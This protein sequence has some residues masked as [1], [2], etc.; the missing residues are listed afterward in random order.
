VGCPEE[1][2]SST[3]GEGPRGGKEGGF[4]KGFARTLAERV[5]RRMKKISGGQLG[6]RN[7]GKKASGN[8]PWTSVMVDD[9]LGRA[10]DVKLHYGSERKKERKKVR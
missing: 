9:R 7:R 4:K 1:K 2:K 6:K 10:V 8:P 3:S 5:F